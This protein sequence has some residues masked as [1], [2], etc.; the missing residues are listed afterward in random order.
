M[1]LKYSFS[2]IFWF[3]VYFSLH[4]HN[5]QLVYLSCKAIP[6]QQKH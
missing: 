6:H 4:L 5:E 2:N 3:D 1:N